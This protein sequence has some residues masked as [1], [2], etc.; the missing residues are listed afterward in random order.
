MSRANL[1]EMPVV[2]PIEDDSPFAEQL[3]PPDFQRQFDYHLRLDV[4]ELSDEV[5][6]GLE[7]M[8]PAHRA[9]WLG[10][11]GLTATVEPSERGHEH[12][13]VHDSRESAIAKIP[14][15]L[16]PADE[17]MWL[18]T[19]PALYGR[20]QTV[21]ERF[22]EN[23]ALFPELEPRTLALP[24]PIRQTRMSKIATSVAAFAMMT[25]GR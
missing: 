17:R 5:V 25:F 10:H 1:L 7:D 13:V 8:W 21:E 18:K 3:L 14:S 15:G 11:Y 2:R 12:L 20:L 4:D 6:N 9:R 24:E 22:E 16:S 23:M 19:N